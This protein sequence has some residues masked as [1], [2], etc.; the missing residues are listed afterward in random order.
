[1]DTLTDKELLLKTADVMERFGWCSGTLQN[2]E[3]EVCLLGAIN[4][5]LGKPAVSFSAYEHRVV[6]MLTKALSLPQTEGGPITAAIMWN[7]RQT[8]GRPVIDGLRRVAASL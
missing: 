7:N 5:A 3:G 2:G 8:S 1:M 6:P 4:I